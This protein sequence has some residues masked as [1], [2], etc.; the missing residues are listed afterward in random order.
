MANL[1]INQPPHNDI[2]TQLCGL[3]KQLLPPSRH[4][5]LRGSKLPSQKFEI[6][7]RARGACGIQSPPLLAPIALQQHPRLPTSHNTRPGV[8]RGLSVL[9]DS[10]GPRH[11]HPR[12]ERSFL[13]WHFQPP[14]LV[15]SLKP[16]LSLY[17]SC[18]S[19]NLHLILS[20]LYCPIS[21]LLYQIE[22]V[23]SHCIKIVHFSA[24]SLLSVIDR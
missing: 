21:L 17:P 13:H 23:K 5:F 22:S 11:P 12:E 18:L 6:T 3:L 10:A 4:F 24:H 15:T 8:H 14:S 9:H 7:M 19:L 16:Q 1:N 2:L 20:V